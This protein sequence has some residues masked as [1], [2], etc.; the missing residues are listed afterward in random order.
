MTQSKSFEK[1]VESK[2]IDIDDDYH[3]LSAEEQEQIETEFKEDKSDD[4]AEEINNKE[5]E[6]EGKRY[7]NPDGGA[8]LYEDELTEDEK[9]YYEEYKPEKEE[10]Q[11]IE[12]WGNTVSNTDNEFEEQQKYFEARA[13]SNNDADKAIEQLQEQ[14]EV[15]EQEEE[16]VA[17]SNEEDDN[18]VNTDT[19]NSSD[20]ADSS[21]SQDSSDSEDNSS[22][23]GGDSSDSGDDSSSSDDGGDSGDSSESE[24]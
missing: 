17:D 6:N 22:D 20:N 13:E 16:E 15:N 3:W 8:P 2:G 18:Q 4:Y 5:E 1:F 10:Q 12:D 9:D 21:D 7:V 23:D 14:E 11:Q 24:E 19:E